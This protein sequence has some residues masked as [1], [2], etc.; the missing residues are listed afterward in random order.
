MNFPQSPGANFPMNLSNDIS[1]RI[2]KKLD[3]IKDIRLKV[4]T[5]FFSND[6]VAK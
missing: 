4:A 5:I 2:S 6:N 3:G 1:I